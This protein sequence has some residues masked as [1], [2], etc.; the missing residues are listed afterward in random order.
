M[1]QRKMEGIRITRRPRRARGFTLVELMVV[2]MIIALLAALGYPSYGNFVTKARRQAARNVIYQ[3]ADRQEQFF[4]DNKVY[5]ANLTT[6]GFAADTIGVDD[7]GQITTSG[8]ADRT[9]VLDLTNTA[10]TTYTV[11]AV[12]Q[13]VQA[14]N[15]TDCMTLTLTHTGVRAQSGSSD[16]C[17]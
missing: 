14:S 10:A 7:N 15:D 11:R 9:Y 13:L 1:E 16:N 6:M 5:A 3:L 2:V 17:W 12:P 4:L 8:D